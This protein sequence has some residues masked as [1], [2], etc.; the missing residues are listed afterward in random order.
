MNLIESSSV[1]QRRIHFIFEQIRVTGHVGDV[2]A[3]LKLYLIKQYWIEEYFF[4]I[5]R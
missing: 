1:G 4:V 3:K 5:V 2:L